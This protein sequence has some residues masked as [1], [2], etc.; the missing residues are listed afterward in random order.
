MATLRE[1]IVTG[2]LQPGQRIVEQDLSARLGVSRTP[3]REAIET[4][5]LDGPVESPAHRGAMVR[6]GPQPARTV[7]V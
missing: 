2:E 1:M 7:T 4:L 5:T 6:R 3:I